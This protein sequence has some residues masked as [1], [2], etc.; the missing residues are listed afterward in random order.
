M[1]STPNPKMEKRE[2]A[3]LFDTVY[4]GIKNTGLTYV[5]KEIKYVHFNPD[6]RFSKAE[7]IE[8]ANALNGARRK[9]KSIQ[10]IINAKQILE[11]NGQ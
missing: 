5:N 2:L 10:K 8:I 11:S 9:N 7:K 4:E 6:C 3:R 1:S